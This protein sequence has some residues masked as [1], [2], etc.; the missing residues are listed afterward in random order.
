MEVYRYGRLSFY[1]G[2][3]LGIDKAVASRLEEKSLDVLPWQFSLGAGAGIALSILPQLSIYFSPGV[4]YYF[5][6]GTSLNTF[7]K[8]HPL[9]FNFSLGVRVTPFTEW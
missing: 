6:D 8:D 7:Y 1:T 5:K 3:E 4:F 2:V 9:N